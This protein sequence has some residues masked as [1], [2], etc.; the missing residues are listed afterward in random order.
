MYAPGLLEHGDIADIVAGVAPRPFFM[1]NGALDPIFPV[2]GVREIAA[3]AAS[4]YSS[5]GASDRFRSVVFEGSH[6]FPD[7]VKAEAYAFLDR[8]LK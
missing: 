6:S 7:G 8:F 4:R 3:L 5:L 2:D 1:A